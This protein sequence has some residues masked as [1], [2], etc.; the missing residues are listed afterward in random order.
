MAQL[1]EAT[2]VTFDGSRDWLA[3]LVN[4]LDRTERL[5]EVPCDAKAKRAMRARLARPTSTRAAARRFARSSPSYSP[6]SCNRGS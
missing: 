4:T 5:S 6:A 1:R 2:R 3:S